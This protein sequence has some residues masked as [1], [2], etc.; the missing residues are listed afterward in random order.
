MSLLLRVPVLL[1]V[2]FVKLVKVVAKAGTLYLHFVLFSAA[3]FPFS[4]I[5]N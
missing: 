1:K 5:N 2:S 3:S 4:L